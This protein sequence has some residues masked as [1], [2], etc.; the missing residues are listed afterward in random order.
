LITP[1]IILFGTLTGTVNGAVSALLMK[2]LI[3]YDQKVQNVNE[4]K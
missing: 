1:A 2:N 4:I 3:K